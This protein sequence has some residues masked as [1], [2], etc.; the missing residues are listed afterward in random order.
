MTRLMNVLVKVV[1]LYMV[2]SGLPHVFTIVASLVWAASAP[3]NITG[4]WFI[5]GSP[6]LGELLGVVAIVKS[7]P[8]A[9]ALLKG[10]R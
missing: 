1:G 3:R 8:I 9:R 5:I 7:E 4:P 6:L 2:L 10:S